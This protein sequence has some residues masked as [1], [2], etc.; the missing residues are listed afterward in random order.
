M[1]K[2]DV[3][4]LLFSL[5]EVYATQGAM[6]ALEERRLAPDH[7]L[8]RHVTGDWGELCAEDQAANQD[9]LTHGLRLLSSY[10]LDAAQKLWIITEAD[11]SSTTLLLPEE[12]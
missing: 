12:Y 9:A 2:G 1:S 11:R 6:A 4:K 10:K 3:R 7:F 8:A 5:G